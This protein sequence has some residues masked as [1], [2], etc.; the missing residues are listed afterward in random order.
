M[1]RTIAIVSLV[2]FLVALAAG[3]SGGSTRPSGTW[4]P[5]EYSPSTAVPRFR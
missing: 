4:A 3:C 5:R 1:C 2:P